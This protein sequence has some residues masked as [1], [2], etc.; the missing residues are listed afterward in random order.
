VICV[1]FVLFCFFFPFCKP[2]NCIN[3]KIAKKGIIF[4]TILTGLSWGYGFRFRA[5]FFSPLDLVVKGYQKKKAQK[6]KG[7][8]KKPKKGLESVKDYLAFVASIGSIFFY[9]GSFWF[10]GVVLKT[11]KQKTLD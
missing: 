4:W 9:R 2:T 8:L 6:E 10:G 11:T 3:N 1:V 5:F 7:A